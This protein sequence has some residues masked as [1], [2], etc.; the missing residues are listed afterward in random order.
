[1]DAAGHRETHDAGVVN[2]DHDNRERAK[3]IETGLTFTILK[4]GIDGFRRQ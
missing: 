2:D 1:M 3:K 4:T